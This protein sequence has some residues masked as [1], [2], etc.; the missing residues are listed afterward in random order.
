MVSIITSLD[1]IVQNVFT[2]AIGKQQRRNLLSI[3]ALFVFLFGVNTLQAQ[4]PNTGNAPTASCVALGTVT[5]VV[6]P[7]DGSA[8]TLNPVDFD[9]N[10]TDDCPGLVLTVSPASISCTDLAGMGSATIAITLTATDAE[11]LTSTCMTDVGIVETIPTAVAQNITVFVDGA[12]NATVNAADID[13]GSQS[14]SA[15]TA[16]TIN[17]GASAMYD[18][19]AIGTPQMAMLVVTNATGMSMPAMAT[20]TVMD[21]INP[22]FT[23]PADRTLP[24]NTSC[25]VTIPDLVAEV[26]DEADNCGA[27]ITVEQAPMAG[28]TVTVM[29]GG[30]TTVTIKVTD[31][32]GNTAD[33]DVTIT[34]DDLIPPTAVAQDITV[35]L[36][37][38]G[39]GSLVA[40]DLDGGSSDNCT[41]PVML[42]AS[43]TSFTCADLG[44]NMV[45]LTAD[46][47][48]GNT[49]DD[50]AMVTV[51]DN[52]P[53]D[54]YLDIGP[55]NS[56][57]NDCEATVTWPSTLN[58]ACAGAVVPTNVTAVDEKGNS[59]PVLIAGP[60][61]FGDFPVGIN[62]V[63]YDV[64]DGTNPLTGETFEIEVVDAEAPTLACPG[65]QT[66]DITSCAPM[67]LVPSFIGLATFSDNCGSNLMVTQMPAPNTDL[68]MVP[69][70]SNPP[71]NGDTYTVMITVT[72]GFTPVTCGPFTV[73]LSEDDAP[74]PDVP[75]A[76]LTMETST[77][78]PLTL[79]APT[80]TDA[81]GNPICGEPFPV[82]ASVWSQVPGTGPCPGSAIS[83]SETGA[84]APINDLS[85]G[86]GFETNSVVNI[87]AS[88]TIG[89]TATLESVGVDISH[90]WNTDLDITLISPAGTELNLSSDNGGTG[91]DYDAIFQDGGMD[92]T[93]AVSP[94]TGVFQA[95]G[96][97]FASTFAGE[98]I[99]GNWT[100]NVCDDEF[101]LSGTLNTWNINFS[102]T[103]GGSVPEYEFQPGNHIITWIYDDGNGN[104]SS[105]LQQ[106]NVSNDAIDP[107]VSCQ[108]IT[109]ELDATGNANIIAND[110]VSAS[111]FTMWF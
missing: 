99:T 6:V 110:L 69:G 8:V 58:D 26:M 4:C 101:I 78:G 12:G 5:G 62:T 106:I 24:L 29:D 60:N 63:T 103:P 16:T 96:G 70:V 85:C 94:I 108:D 47:G 93:N 3:F 84:G 105:Q 10:S 25:Q 11:G 44:A 88:G 33:C 36:N 66:Q 23:C 19:T 57:V 95:E 100:L 17:G 45:T 9:D 46:D 20:I 89:S 2:K 53:P 79:V 73:T 51:V 80:A 75:G 27:P 76:T 61:F 81:C 42:S 91:D 22:S 34:G 1:N 15:I 77:C 55:F 30:S 56:M 86:T 102:T 82:D 109:L 37:D 104:S 67:Q 92:V 83:I 72:D 28:A 98:S 68:T 13:G 107:V 71:A 41:S 38:M 32:N 90:T 39:N 48:N 54:T 64:T 87:T 43:T 52:T 49:H 35:N 111:G 97:T 65:D 18:C 14:C 31:S 21:N 74:Q 50:I 7:A 59:V 40:A